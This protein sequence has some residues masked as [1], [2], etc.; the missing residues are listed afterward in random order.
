M[1]DAA[2]EVVNSVVLFDPIVG[3]GHVS[4]LLELMRIIGVNYI[5]VICD[6]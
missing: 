5:T 3:V 2:D 4:V 6:L 1:C